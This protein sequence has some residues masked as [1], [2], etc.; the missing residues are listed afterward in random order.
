MK[1]KK[2]E[3]SP[4]NKEIV[5]VPGVLRRFIERMSRRL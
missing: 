1:K 5:K 4:R 2:N 3:A